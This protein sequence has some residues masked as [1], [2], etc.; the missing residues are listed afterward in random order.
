MTDVFV[1]VAK[2]VVIHRVNQPRH[3][4]LQSTLSVPRVQMAKDEQLMMSIYSG[5]ANEVIRAGW[6]QD[7]NG[8]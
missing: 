6:G 1:H 5:L 7:V 3:V 4:A 2:C 8:G